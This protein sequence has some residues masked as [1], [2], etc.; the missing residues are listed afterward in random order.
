MNP[1]SHEILFAI[2]SGVI[3]SVVLTTFLEKCVTQLPPPPPPPPPPQQIKAILQG[4][5]DGKTWYTIDSLEIPK[6]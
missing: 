2:V 1:R 3:L 6:P 5:H 4:S